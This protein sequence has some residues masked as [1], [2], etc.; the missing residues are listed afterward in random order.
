MTIIALG[1]IATRIALL[2]QPDGGYY[3]RIF[4]MG[5]AAL[6]LFVMVLLYTFRKRFAL[7]LAPRWK[8]DDRQKQEF[9]QAALF[10][11]EL[12]SK[13]QQGLLSEPDEIRETGQNMISHMSISSF[14]EVK[15]NDYD[16]H[17]EPTL[18]RREPLGRLYRWYD[19]H[20]YLGV[21]AFV[22]CLLHTDLSPGRSLTTQIVFWL[23]W[24]VT[25]TGIAGGLIHRMVPVTLT[26]LEENVS[27]EQ[28]IYLR[29]QLE[30]K[31]KDLLHNR[32][33]EFLKAY[34]T[35]H[36]KNTSEAVQEAAKKVP[37]EEQ[38]A[39]LQATVFKHQ[40]QRITK[41]Y[42]HIRFIHTVLRRWMIF[43]VP[44]AVALFVLTLLHVA[45]VLYY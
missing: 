17:L 30:Q 20:L 28:L 45:A 1:L 32:S 23:V 18:A 12:K 34:R 16:G 13:I 42:G 31:L 4:I 3:F 29:E 8:L 22:V 36:K 35:I 7:W 15:V 26:R 25:I 40:L 21:L 10:L 24:L 39:F 5:W 9:P 43:H 44:F 38:E 33:A 11:Q 6:A 27:L 37:E 14:V 19:A 2:S 41:R